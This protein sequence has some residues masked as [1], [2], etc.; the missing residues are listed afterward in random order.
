MLQSDTVLQEMRVTFKYLI[1]IPCF[2]SSQL[3]DNVCTCDFIFL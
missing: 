1:Y 2:S 3:I